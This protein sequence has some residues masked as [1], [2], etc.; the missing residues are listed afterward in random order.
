MDT[1]DC[2]CGKHASLS[3]T[4]L[5]EG[6]DTAAAI[7]DLEAALTQLENQSDD[8]SIALID[9]SLED[10]ALPFE[11]DDADLPSLA[12]VLA[13]LERYPGLKITLSF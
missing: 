3:M 13:M 5:G 8:L 10:Q 9:D 12:T 11:S 7:Q 1:S 6:D 2:G 4:S